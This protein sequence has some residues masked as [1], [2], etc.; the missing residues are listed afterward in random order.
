MIRLWAGQQPFLVIDSWSLL[1]VPLVGAA[2]DTNQL[3]FT[4][5]WPLL[6]LAQSLTLS[7]LEDTPSPMTDKYVHEGVLRLSLEVNHGRV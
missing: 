2:A 6:A 4:L 7:W 1:P 5:Y 3:V